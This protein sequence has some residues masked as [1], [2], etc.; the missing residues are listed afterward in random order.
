MLKYTFK[1]VNS[2]TLKDKRTQIT[3]LTTEQK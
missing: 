2:L 1:E 3:C